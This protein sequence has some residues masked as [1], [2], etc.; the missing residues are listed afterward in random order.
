METHSRF[1]A[2]LAVL[3]LLVAGFLY[4]LGAYVGVY[5][6]A[7]DS[8]IVIL[9]PPN[10]ILLAALLCWPLRS[11][12][13]LCAVI[14]VAEVV[15]DIPAFTVSQALLFGAINITECL[16]AAGLIRFRL[17][18]EIDWHQPRELSLFLVTV[19]VIASPIA[20][21]GGASV[22]AF[23]LTSDTPFLTFW[24]LWWI[25][26]ATGLVVLTPVLHMLFS[27]G[28]KGLLVGG[29]W[30][31]RLELMGAWG[32]GLIACY[33][34]FFQELYSDDYLALSPLMVI[35]APLWLAIRFGAFEGSLLATAVALGVAFAT[36]AGAGP[37]VRDEQ[38]YSALLTQEFAILF[39]A[40][41]LYVAAFMR[42]SRKTSCELQRALAEVRQLNQELEQR[43]SER[44]R[45]LYEANHQLKRQASTDDLTGILNRR[46]MKELG[47]DEARRSDRSQRTFSVLLLDID[48]FKGIND[49][50]GHAVGDQCLKAFVQ[51]I[52]PSLR[53][54]DRFGRWGGEEFMIL[55]PDSGHVD[56]L[57]FSEK[58]L[59]CV[60]DVVVLCG[61]QEIKMTVSIGVADW[62][63][64]SF[65]RLVSDADDALY[66]A[67]SQGRNRAAFNSRGLRVTE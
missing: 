45:A 49:R 48:Y 12:W 21:V 17:R 58:L 46:S 62:H 66:R 37:F 14:L 9:W 43:V 11:W 33:M 41:V 31:R 51:A 57:H 27:Y 29:G 4:Y 30:H 7:L 65:D 25:G 60:R 50:C 3:P 5:Y 13:A 38:E 34:V 23:L 8:G 42:Q 56:L 26:D 15:A 16:L 2:N 1:S 40:M 44:T 6:A 35:V 47:E 39:T 36:A 64:S 63:H 61:N 20:A 22:Y 53:A 54:I 24:R 67:K 10:A 52:A 28:L 32:L 55:V 59:K 18:R 19:C